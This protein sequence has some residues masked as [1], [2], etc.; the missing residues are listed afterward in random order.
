MEPSSDDQQWALEEFGHAELGDLRRTQR[1]VDVAHT[2]LIHPRGCITGTFEDPAEREAAFRWVENRAICVAE[3]TRASAR[4]AARRAAEFSF[5]FVPIDGTALSIVDHLRQKGIGVVGARQSGARGI[6]TLSAIVVAPTGTPLG[7]GYQ[8]MWARRGRKRPGGKLG[9]RKDRRQLRS[10]ETHHWLDAMTNVTATFRDQAPTTQ[11]WVQ[12]DRGGDSWEV[13]GCAHDLGLLATV[14]ASADR[15][16]W[17]EKDQ[18]RRYLRAQVARQPVGGYK[19][20]EVPAGPHRRARRAKLAVRFA[21]VELDLHNSRGKQRRRV[22]LWAVHVRELGTT[23]NGEQPLDWM[24]LTTYQVA[25]LADAEVVIHGYATRWAIEEF[26]KTWKSDACNVEAMQL[27]RFDN[28]CRWAAVLA[29]VAMRI[30]RLMKLARNEPDLPATVELT[31]GE[32]KAIIVSTRSRML[33]AKPDELLTIGEA[34]KWL[35]SL[36]GHSPS[37]SAGPPGAKTL[38]RGLERITLLAA[39]FDGKL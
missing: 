36:G 15:R 20:I 27:R 8:A 37:P 10:R 24:L 5:A 2:A 33:T 39:H 19:W 26:H 1:L 25:T 22:P 35:G 31:R 9:G 13:L 34:V 7:I 38:M 14:R 6:Q 28:I 32:I 12:L 11:P 3:V 4:A 21:R 17:T 30:Q 16:L 23:P 18:P 29:A